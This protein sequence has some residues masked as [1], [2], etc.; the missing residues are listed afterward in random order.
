MF[1]SDHEDD[2]IT[3][4][5]SHLELWGNSITPHNF[6]FV[7]ITK[8]ILTVR[9]YFRCSFTIPLQVYSYIYLMVLKHFSI[10]FDGVF[11]ILKILVSSPTSRV[12][13]VCVWIGSPAP[14]D[15]TKWPFLLYITEISVLFIVFLYAAASIHCPCIGHSWSQ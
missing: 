2:D 1:L 6:P 14:P 15:L 3:T 12:L 11:P 5:T 7:I 9:F 4:L 10:I 8:C 13:V